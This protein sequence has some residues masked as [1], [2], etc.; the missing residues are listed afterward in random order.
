MFFKVEVLIK[1]YKS[2]ILLKFKVLGQTLVCLGPKMSFK[3]YVHQKVLIE[4]CTKN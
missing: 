2:K 1:I 3:F 4:A